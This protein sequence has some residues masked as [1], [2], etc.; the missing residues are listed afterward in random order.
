MFRLENEEKDKGRC[1]PSQ[2]KVKAGSFVYGRER[3][4][5]M[6]NNGQEEKVPDEAKC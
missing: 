2:S 5:L 4:S 1:L 3:G 6:V